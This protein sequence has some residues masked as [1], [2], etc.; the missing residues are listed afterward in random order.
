MTGAAFGRRLECDYNTESF[1][2]WH[3]HKRCRTESVDYSAKFEPEKHSF[4]G[5]STV[6]SGTTTFEISKS[7]K[8]EF[9]PLDILTEFPKLNGL[10]IRCSNLPTI[11]AGLFKTELDKIEY[12]DLWDSKIES[13]ELSAFQHLI[14]LRWIS[15]GSNKIETLS[16]QIFKNNPLLIY[17]NLY[18]SQINSVHPNF[19]DDLHKLKLIEFDDKDLC[20]KTKVGCETCQITQKDL[21]EKLRDCFSNCS[22]N[23]VCQGTFQSSS[24]TEKPV[25]ETIFPVKVDLKEVSTNFSQGLESISRD[26]KKAI[27]GVEEK[28]LNI[29]DDL[30][31]LVA[32]LVTKIKT[33]NELGRKTTKEA[34]DTNNQKIQ[35]CCASHKKAVEKLEESIAEINTCFADN[36]AEISNLKMEALE[37]NCAKKDLEIE[38]LKREVKGKKDMESLLSGL[39]QE[40]TVFIEAKLKVLKE[41]LIGNGA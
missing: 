31:T 12:L 10:M 1:T 38:S 21:K 37:A 41:E 18:S 39:K 19:F 33:E 36:Q 27:E 7:P 24:T 34:I 40:L 11:K 9:I 3:S 16:H 28:L 32:G 30:K 4:T 5:N 22:N 8:V 23:T 2:L 6:K 29:T 26:T 14:K 17:I 13:I 35:E 20:I 15:L 25:N